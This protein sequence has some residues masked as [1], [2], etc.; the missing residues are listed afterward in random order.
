VYYA[1]K[2]AP[3]VEMKI[4]TNK[5]AIAVIQQTSLDKMIKK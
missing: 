4:K 5:V 2:K 3:A 1:A